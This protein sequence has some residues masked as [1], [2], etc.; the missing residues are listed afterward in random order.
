MSDPIKDGGPA[1]PGVSDSRIGYDEYH[2][3]YTHFEALPGMTIRDWFA[4]QS[5]NEASMLETEA[6]TGPNS[7]PSYD[8]I[9]TRAYLI[10]GAMIKAREAQQ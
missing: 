10:A 3:G 6:P 8:G 7:E 1:F 2:Q 9:A 5:I 4:G